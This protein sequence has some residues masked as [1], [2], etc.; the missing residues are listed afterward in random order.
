MTFDDL[1]TTFQELEAQHQVLQTEHANAAT[2][3]TRLTSENEF[4]KLRVA[5]LT[6][7]L[8][9]KSSE[10]HVPSGSQQPSLFEVALSSTPQAEETSEVAAHTR[11]I[12]RKLDESGAEQE[13]GRFPEHLPRVDDPIEEFPEGVS[14]E[15]CYFVECKI[16][17]RLAERPSELYV[18]RTIRKIYKHKGTGKFNNPPA[19]EHVFGRCSVHESF[20]VMMVIKKFLWHLP[21]YRQH[22]QAKLSGVNL[23]RANFA[24]WVIKF[25]ALLASVAKALHSEVLGAPILHCDETPI[26]VGKRAAGDT[27]KRYNDG[28]LWPLV[29]PGIGVSFTYTSGRGYLELKKI[30][31]VFRGTLVS[32]AYTVYEKF[33]AE[34][35]CQWQLCFMHIRRNFVDAQKSNKA[36]ADEGLAFIRRLYDVEAAVQDKLPDKRLMLRQEHSRKILDE[37][38]AWLKATAA[39]PEAITSPLLSEAISYVY[40]RWDAACL[41]LQDGR[42]PI[43]NGAAERTIRP[44][45]LGAKNWM[46]ASSEVGAETLATFY[47]L[48]LT[49]MMQGVHPYYYLMDLCKRI[50]QPGLKA[51]DLVPHRWK[52]RFFEQAVPVEFRKIT[53]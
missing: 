27:R 10:R 40:T 18:V 53:A 9:G 44:T 45:K 25:G 1:L 3:V 15:D 22:Q 4:L 46:F 8:Y 35:G 30:L 37:F 49:S 31:S 7:A 47:S 29:A 24:F 50:D 13:L 19:P 36:R 33:V 21:L 23:P 43:D 17:E 12:R 51:S 5:N 41:F 38:H 2:A 48:I 11:R 52:E 28:Y 42:I 39:T 32:D 26:L 14:K 16:T 6:H 20:L 34:F